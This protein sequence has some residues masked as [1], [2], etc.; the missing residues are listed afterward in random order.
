[1]AVD[2][3]RLLVALGP[4]AVYLFVIGLINAAKRPIVVSGVRDTIGLG[5]A[6]A[7][8]MIVGPL[9]MFMP[10]GATSLFGPFIWLLLI[11]FY[12]LIVTFIL[13]NERPRIIVYNVPAEVLHPLVAQVAQSLDSDS[14][15]AGDTLALPA[16][17]VEL[18]LEVSTPLRNVSL[19]ANGDRQSI[20]A[21][22]VLRRSLRAALRP[23]RVPRNLNGF[24]LIA[25]S[26]FVMAMLLWTSAANPDAV[27]QN[28]AQLLRLQ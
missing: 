26:L 2:P 17:G 1:M 9:E 7:G 22:Q 11:S 21:W 28:L 8:L 13:L 5:L 24:V 27:A 15:W 20:V 25:T 12:A 16:L 19:V 3:F 23:I 18:R 4:L 10:Q 6:L 14:R